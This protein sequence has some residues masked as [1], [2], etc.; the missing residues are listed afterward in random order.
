MV[1]YSRKM[2]SGARG[3]GLGLK[4]RSRNRFEERGEDI[5]MKE[6]AK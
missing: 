3:N 4:R 5:R 2:G 1:T 6:L